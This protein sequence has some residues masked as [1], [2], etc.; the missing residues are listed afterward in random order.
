MTK[1]QIQKAQVAVQVLRQVAAVALLNEADR[2]NANGA[3]N[4]LNELLAAE[5]RPQ[6]NVSPPSS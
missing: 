5:A 2:N 1:D 6:E 4:Y 3:V